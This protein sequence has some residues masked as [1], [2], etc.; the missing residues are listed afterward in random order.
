MPPSIQDLYDYL[1]SCRRR[2]AAGEGPFV[3]E[4]RSGSWAVVDLRSPQEPRRWPLSE[5][6]ARKEVEDLNGRRRDSSKLLFIPSVAG[7]EGFVKSYLVTDEQGR[8]LGWVCSV[9]ES[10]PLGGCG[11]RVVETVRWRY[12]RTRSDPWSEKYFLKRQDAAAS[13]Q[14]TEVQIV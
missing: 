8:T 4:A 10:Y 6:S 13:L 5:E 12:R 3:V 1:D 7:C 9:P 11:G 14:A 2:V